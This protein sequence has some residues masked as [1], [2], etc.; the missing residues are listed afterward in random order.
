MDL[1]YQTSKS[2]STTLQWWAV[3]SDLEKMHKS[4][5]ILSFLRIGRFVGK[6]GWKVGELQNGRFDLRL[7]CAKR[8]VPVWFMMCFSRHTTTR[9]SVMDKF[10]SMCIDV[11]G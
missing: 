9:T 8:C 6:S 3:D 5:H 4:E 11:Y 1:T 2:E 10:H 7:Q